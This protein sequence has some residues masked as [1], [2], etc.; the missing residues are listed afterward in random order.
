MQLA[1]HD[2]STELDIRS[3][4]N[5]LTEDGNSAVT[6]QASLFSLLDIHS[7][8]SYCIS[9]PPSKLPISKRPVHPLYPAYPASLPPHRLL[10]VQL[11]LLFLRAPS[12]APAS[13]QT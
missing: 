4:A 7:R 2:D 11:Y 13:T 9:Q 8:L 12:I 5:D 1:A 3:K 6:P 10:P